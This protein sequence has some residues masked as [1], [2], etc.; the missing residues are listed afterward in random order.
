MLSAPPPP[1]HTHTHRPLGIGMHFQSLLSPLLKVPRMEL[2]NSLLWCELGTNLPGHGPGVWLS[3]LRVTSFIYH[4]G[5]PSNLELLH[6]CW[7]VPCL[8]SWSRRNGLF[9]NTAKKEGSFWKHC[10]ERESFWKHCEERE[11]FLKTLRRKRGLFENT[12]KKERS[13]WKHGEEREVF[14]KLLRRKRYFWKQC[15]ERDSDNQHGWDSNHHT[16]Q[17][18][19]FIIKLWPGVGGTRT[20]LG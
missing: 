3:F 20:F 10:E 4:P 5:W 12:A 15:E 18:A 13:F 8:S 7:S 11:V 19:N 1:P 17:K 2:L 16:K 9:E 6:F 14:L